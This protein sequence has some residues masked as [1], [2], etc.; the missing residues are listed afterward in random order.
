[1]G[2]LLLG[3]VLLLSLLLA[4]HS[5][6]SWRS[7]HVLSAL[8]LGHHLLLLCYDP[9]LVFDSESERQSN[10]ECRGGDDPDEFAGEQ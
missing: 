7:E 2:R 6:G 5:C 3:L 9:R 1:M 10:K 4:R 8:L